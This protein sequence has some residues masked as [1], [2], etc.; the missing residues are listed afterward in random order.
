MANM[1]KTKKFNLEP[2]K[3]KEKKNYNSIYIVSKKIKVKLKY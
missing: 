2:K 1:I 3:K